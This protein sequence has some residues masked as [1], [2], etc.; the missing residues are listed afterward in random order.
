MAQWKTSLSRIPPA[1]NSPPGSIMRGPDPSLQR[2][3]GAG[4]KNGWPERLKT[5]VPGNN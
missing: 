4:V 1:P 2:G 5:G 3:A